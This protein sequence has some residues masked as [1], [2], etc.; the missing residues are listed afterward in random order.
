MKIYSE[1]IWKF[2]EKLNKYVEV[3]SNCSDYSGPVALCGDWLD[4]QDWYTEGQ[5]QDLGSDDP[6]LET[7]DEESGSFDFSKGQ[8]A[9]TDMDGDG[10]PEYEE[11][12]NGDGIPDYQQMGPTPGVGYED[13]DDSWAHMDKGQYG[14]PN[15]DPFDDPDVDPIDDPDVDPID[16]YTWENPNTEWFDTEAMGRRYAETMALAG[17]DYMGSEEAKLFW[18]DTLMGL[19]TDMTQE[20][21]DTVWEN[22]GED[23]GTI[24][25]YDPNELSRLSRQRQIGLQQLGS[26][27]GGDPSLSHSIGTTGLG[28]GSG[29]TGLGSGVGAWDQHAIDTRSL[30]QAFQQDTSAYWDTLGGNIFDFATKIL[31]PEG[32]W[33]E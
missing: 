13:P 33:F 30:N 18:Q 4:D 2:D 15:A 27:F 8:W 9:H 20:Q 12:N 29:L 31:D 16:Y 5:G 21:F 23:L 17:D 25:G 32:T 28:L 19:N 26:S 14:D 6:Y 3:S 11:D 7:W 22:F 10:I 24:H 1:V